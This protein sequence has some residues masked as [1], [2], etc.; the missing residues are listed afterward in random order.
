MNLFLKH[1]WVIVLLSSCLDIEQLSDDSTFSQTDTSTDQADQIENETQTEITTQTHSD[2]TVQTQTESTDSQQTLFIQVKASLN[3]LNDPLPK[4]YY[5][6]VIVPARENYEIALNQQ[7]VTTATAGLGDIIGPASGLR[8]THTKV[9]QSIMIEQSGT[10]NIAV[11][12]EIETQFYSV[13]IA[14]SECLSNQ[15]YYDQYVKNSTNQCLN[16]HSQTGSAP[17]SFSSYLDIENYIEGHH[18]TF[19]AQPGKT[20]HGGGK[21][22]EQNDSMHQRFLNLQHRIVNNWVCL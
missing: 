13:D 3:T 4:T 8:S 1:L 19:A 12:N 6:E 7:V 18:T 21:R 11:Q 5:F 16:C 2:T 9:L 20:Y 15:Q 10:Y 17:Y 14:N 22:F